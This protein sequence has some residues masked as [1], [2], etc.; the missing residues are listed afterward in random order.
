MSE[1]TSG[2]NIL[3]HVTVVTGDMTPCEVPKTIRKKLI[4][5]CSTLTF[6]G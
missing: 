2:Q 1:N 5:L 4:N 6:S 3:K